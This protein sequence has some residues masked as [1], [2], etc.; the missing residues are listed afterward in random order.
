MHSKKSILVFL[1]LLVL[2]ALSGCHIKAAE[3]LYSPPKRSEGYRGLQKKIDSAMVGLDYSAPISG[4]NQQ[5]VQLADLDG[6]GETEYI[7]FAK[8]TSEHP[9]QI[10]IFDESQ[11]EYQL[12][13]S[14]SSPGAAFEQVEYVQMDENPG[15]EMVVGYQLSGEVMRIVSVYSLH[16]AQMEQLVKTNYSKFVC[17]DLDSD[18]K[19]EMLV[20][21]P[22]EDNT[23]NGIAEL[24]S[25]E[26]GSAERSAEVGLSEPAEQIKRIMVSRLEGGKPAV[27]VASE[28]ETGTIVTDVYAMVDG[29][30]TNVSFSHEAG[31]SVQTYR[32]Y[33]VYADDIDDDGV[34]ELPNLIISQNSNTQDHDQHVIRW[35]A[36]T[37]E[38]KEIDKL[39]TFHNYVGGWYISLDSDIAAML[40]VVQMGNS[41]DFY[42]QSDSGQ[43]AEKIMTIYALTGQKREEQALLNNRFVLFRTESTVYAAHLEVASGAYGMS[44]EGLIASFHLIVQDWKT[45]ET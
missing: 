42:I 6:D 45:G 36:M 15:L 37:P 31:T 35:Y 14:V 23:D 44:K 29:Q 18:G 25:I 30:F 11:G 19:S 8:G 22:D 32:N 20:L 39:Y 2:V 9:M 40:Q 12:M 27:Y 38:G 26:N 17:C 10:F 16:D 24:F 4:E 33:Y 1:A 43:E 41:Y 3:E 13:D 21:R 7:L 28:V 5:T 34:L